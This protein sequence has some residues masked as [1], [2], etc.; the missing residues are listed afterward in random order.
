MSS[1]SASEDLDFFLWPGPASLFLPLLLC[2]AVNYTFEKSNHFGQFFYGLTLYRQRPS[3][4]IRSA[5]DP[6]YLQSFFLGCIV[7]HRPVSII[8]QLESLDL[9]LSVFFILLT[10]QTKQLNSLSICFH[11]QSS[12]FGYHQ[13]VL[14]I[15]ELH[16][17]VL[18]FGVCVCI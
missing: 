3:S 14:C 15:Y 9:L 8:L 18:L 4:L 16:L 12:A 6:G 17:F 10:Q 5:R 1:R 13:S 2:F 7:F 11:L